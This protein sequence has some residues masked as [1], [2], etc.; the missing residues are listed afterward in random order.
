MRCRIDSIDNRTLNILK[1]GQTLPFTN[2][3]NTCTSVDN[4]QCVLC[5][6]LLGNYDAADKNK[7]LLKIQLVTL[8][9]LNAGEVNFNTK[10]K[11]DNNGY[12]H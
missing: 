3:V 2:T 1:Q 7:S 6:I 5:E 10:H 4:Q 12:I 11:I 9:K 8:P